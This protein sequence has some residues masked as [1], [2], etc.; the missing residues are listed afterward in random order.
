MLDIKVIRENS[1]FVKEN[2]KKKFQ[3]EKLP[4]VDKIL[5]LDEDWRKNKIQTRNNMYWQG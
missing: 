5:Q 4:L 1:E 2:I 3:D